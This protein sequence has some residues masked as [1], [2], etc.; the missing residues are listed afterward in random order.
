MKLHSQRRMII[1]GL[2]FPLVSLG[3]E[4]KGPEK[5]EAPPEPERAQ[6][7]SARPM[8]P[9]AQPTAAR[10]PE[11]TG[12]PAAEAP[13]LGDPAAAMVSDGAALEG[14]KLMLTGIV[15]TVPEGWTMEDAGPPSPMGPKAV[16]RIPSESGDGGTVR[17]THFPGMKGKDDLNVAR[18]LAQVVKPDGS[19][20]TPEEAKIEKKEIG[21]V[22][23]TIVD[24]SGSVKLTMRDTPR[25]GTRMIAA[26]V[27]HPQGPHF[28][29]A[30]GDIAFMEKQAGGV[31]AFLE[32]AR[33]Q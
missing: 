22:R 32:S 6:P 24:A 4:Q 31:T 29:V 12:E 10:E 8:P 19:P 33:V 11:T 7:A 5:T 30:A 21:D 2:L 25:P 28:V 13:K 17:I 20:T 23:L 1:L 18:W 14:D 3:C 16:L 26:I 15:M 9:A 27:D